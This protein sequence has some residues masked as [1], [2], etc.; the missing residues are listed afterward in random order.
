MI[1]LVFSRMHLFF[2]LSFL[3]YVISFL[4]Y[5]LF[6]LKRKWIPKL[7]PAL[8]M[9]I[10]FVFNTAL[11]IVSWVNYKQPPIRTLYETL[12]FFAWTVA[13]I[14]LI[15][16]LITKLRVVGI[17]A[18]L[19]SVISLIYAIFKVDVDRINLPAALQSFWFIPHVI[20]YFI[21][22]AAL[23]LSFVTAILYLKFPDK[24]KLPKGHWL[25]QEY[26]NFESYTY[27]IINFGFIF[28]SLGLLLGGVWAKEAW[29]DYWGWDPKENWSLIT[30]LVYLIYLHLRFVKGWRGKRAAYFAIAG[31]VAVIITYL[32]VNVLP[33][34]QESLHTYQ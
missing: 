18:S 11:I 1:L 25:E 14:Y 33:S 2:K 23:F 8:S 4:F 21:A 34:A 7:F 32:G 10:A 3:F 19:F 17:F 15:I 9:L 13:F 24:K 26:L 20:I 6:F 27:K 22:Y 5:L 31:F 12:V 30:W 29:G 28:L 16:E